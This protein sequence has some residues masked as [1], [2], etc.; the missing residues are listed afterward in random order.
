MIDAKEYGRALFLLTEENGT[1]ETAVLE[2]RSVRTL[3]RQNPSYEKL[4]DTPALPKDEKLL[5]IDRAVASLDENVVNLVKILCELHA[6]FRF[7]KIAE[8]YDSFYD[9]SRGI[10]RVEAVT[11]VAMSEAQ[12]SAMKKKMEALTGK[13]IIIKNTVDKNILG[14]VVLRYSGTQLDGSL[15]TRLDGFEKSLKSIVL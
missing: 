9:E 14:G 12:L 11:A 5:L 4:L 10:E 2:V 13:H 8:A 3:L 1:T 6:V 7:S 15:K